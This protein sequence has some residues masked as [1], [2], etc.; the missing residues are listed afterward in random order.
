MGRATLSLSILLLLALAGCFGAGTTPTT[1]GTGAPGAQAGY[2]LDCGLS[3]WNETCLVRASPNDSP[4]KSEIDVA[5]NPADPRNVFVASKDLD[6][7]ASTCVW[8]VGQYT[9]DGGRTWNTTYLGGLAAERGPANPLYGWHCITDPI[10]QYESDGTLHYSLQ[11]YEYNPANLPYFQ[12]P[13]GLASLPPTMGYMFHAISHD[14]GATFPTMFIQH[15]GDAGFVYHDYMRMG[16]NPR[17]DT[18]FT[19]WN[20]LSPGAGSV[21]VV[22]AVKHGQTVAQPPYYF[23]N[24]SNAQ[25]AEGQGISLGES[26]VVGASDGTVYA[27]LSGFNSGGRAV[28]SLSN[29]DGATFTQPR[30]VW[31]FTPMDDLNGTEFRTGTSVELAVDTSGGPRDGC[32]H[33]VWGGKE[34][35]TVGPSDIYARSSC[36]KGAT[37][38]EP[39]LVNALHRQDGQFMPRVSVDGHGAVHAVY[40]T[41]A[42][43]E[44]HH[45]L[46]IDAEHASSTDGGKTW[47]QRRL[48]G[49]SFD[50]DLG[51]HQDG[52]PFIGDYIGISSVG[53]HTWMGFPHT[54]TGRAEIAV[55]HVVH[56]DD[57][58][59]IDHGAHA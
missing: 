33:A 39:V 14:G 8:A 18:V 45:H 41:R 11:A 34:A 5:V 54:M 28:L 38:S 43:D 47:A 30:Q 25:D 31:S 16:R 58:S 51:V 24:L 13:T 40:M 37:W 35:G 44:A 10:L 12:D 21:P 32:L 50:G 29:D 36:D 23:P 46:W 7:K 55:A 53:D 17:T 57:G 27:W 26:A 56:D 19:I 49:V 2:R 52:F 15:V 20:Q 42:Y 1:S 48:T 9:K 3:N 22:V 59:G 6:R 4:S